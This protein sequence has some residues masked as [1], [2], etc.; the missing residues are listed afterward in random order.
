MEARWTFLLLPPLLPAP[1]KLSLTAGVASADRWCEIGIVIE[2]T[3]GHLSLLDAGA[4]VGTG[5]YM[6]SDGVIVSPVVL[7]EVVAGAV[8]TLIELEGGTSS[9]DGW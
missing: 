2:S 1:I 3:T 8:A 7:S 5:R 9:A 6:G 4:G